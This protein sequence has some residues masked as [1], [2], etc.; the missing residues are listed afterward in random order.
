M[1][2]AVAL[3]LLPMA[4]DLILS[5]RA[6]PFR[7][8]AAD[9]FYYHTVA[10]NIVELG[11]PTF[12]QSFATNG[13][14]PLW[15]LTLAALYAL[16]EGAG[17]SEMFYLYASLALG[18]L[19]IAGSIGLLASTLTLGGRPLPPSFSL[20]AVGAY[21]CLA[22]PA[23]LL[24]YGYLNP[25]EGALPLYG[26]LFSYANG[27]E[28]AFAL[29]WHAV[30]LRLIADPR[31]R[32]WG[33]GLA[34]GTCALLT[35]LSRLDHA[36]LV[37][38][39]LG[40]A[41][42]HAERERRR[43]GD[44]AAWSAALCACGVFAS[45]LG[46]YLVINY[47][48]A[49]SAMPI[50]GSAKSTFPRPHLGG[51]R[52][53]F[54][55]VSRSPLAPGWLDSFCRVAQ[56]VVPAL[57]ALAWLAHRPAGTTRRHIQRLW[58]DEGTDLAL[59]L[60]A[61]GVLLLSAYDFSFVPTGAIGPWY[62]PVSVVFVSVVV[63]RLV[64]DIPALSEP[65][66]TGWQLVLCALLCVTVFISL[67][68]RESYHREFADLYLHDAARML[69]HYRGQ[70]VKLVEAD[71]G[72]VAFSTGLPCISYFGFTDDIESA[73]A[74]RSGAWLS[75]LRKRGI[76]RWVTLA[77]APPCR[78]RAST[79]CDAKFVQGIEQVFGIEHSNFSVEYR[80]EHTRLTVVSFAEQ[81]QPAA[82]SVGHSQ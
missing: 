34:I 74:R 4:F 51:V 56:L 9:A 70:R 16:V 61:F 67:H 78:A 38:P 11:F 29:F 35:T 45:L 33:F 8:F 13:F 55:L 49:G 22:L 28:S 59:S 44:R 64:Q 75:L 18:A 25:H 66:A 10:R 23:W 41:V 12:D 39:V 31:W 15:Q 43:T 21:G 7:Y 1:A 36:L 77:Y 53:L 54:G 50:S 46:A 57:F 32:S 72:I 81:P 60:T 37:A 79:H 2:A 40:Y 82:V 26:T 27:M 19:A 80:S 73:R 62:T 58:L 47:L 5:S 42:V 24:A 6:A 20:I 48:Y 69:K 63:L 68:R 65:R 17:G 71:D 52:W 76:D 3:F 30:L 14:H